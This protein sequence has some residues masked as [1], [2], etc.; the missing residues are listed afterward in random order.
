MEGPATTRAR[1]TLAEPD[2][3]LYAS[4]VV[5]GLWLQATPHVTPRLC[6]SR[7]G[8]WRALLAPSQ[9]LLGSRA[10]CSLSLLAEAILLGSQLLFSPHVCWRWSAV[11]FQLCADVTCDCGY[12]LDLR[13]IRTRHERQCK[14]SIEEKIRGTRDW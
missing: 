13:Y 4:L 11:E 2:S 12:G 6:G 5:C 9:P 3:C 14:F 10:L 1:G 8:V 7:V